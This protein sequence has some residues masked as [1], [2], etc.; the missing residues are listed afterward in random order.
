MAGIHGNETD[1]PNDISASLGMASRHQLVRLTRY[2][3]NLGKSMICSFAQ[4]SR[5]SDSIY[6]A[7]A[8]PGAGLPG[9]TIQ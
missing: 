7:S 3:M 4:A 8:G 5:M 1:Y 2:R 9:K 6:S